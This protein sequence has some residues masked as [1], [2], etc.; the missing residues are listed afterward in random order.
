MNLQ[1]LENKLLMCTILLICSPALL[2][3]FDAPALFFIVSG[4][5]ALNIAALKITM[6]ALNYKPGMRSLPPSKPLL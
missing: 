1:H 6:F 3:W 4:A 2:L 5:V